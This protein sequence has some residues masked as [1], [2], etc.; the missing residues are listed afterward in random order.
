[1]SGIYPLS[2][3]RYRGQ[4]GA[5]VDVLAYSSCYYTLTGLR[6]FDKL[7]RK[8]NGQVVE[9]DTENKS[10]YSSLDPA[11]DIAHKT[12]E[13]VKSLERKGCER[14]ERIQPQTMTK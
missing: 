13:S 11:T 8:R 4:H 2:L 5:G 3:V 6:K 12:H 7:R 10:D 1:M 14:V 9:R